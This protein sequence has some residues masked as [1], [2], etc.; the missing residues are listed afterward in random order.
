MTSMTPSREAGGRSSVRPAPPL[1]LVCAAGAWVAV[2]VLWLAMGAMPGTMGLSPVLFLGVWTLMMAAMMLP[3]VAPFGSFYT[4]TFT[5]HRERRLVAFVSGYLLAWAGAGVPA[6][7]LAWSVDRF[8]TGRATAATVLAVLIFLLCGVYQLT[9][10]KD[11][12]LAHCRSP[13]GFTLKYSTY[14]GRGRDLRAGALHGGFCLGCCWALMLV[15]IA[16]GLMNVLAMVGIAAVVTIEKNWR[17]G[18]P[19]ARTAGVVSIVLAAAVAVHPALAPG[20]YQAPRSTMTNG[21]M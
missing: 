2:G 20:L 8:I 7:A 5:V 9:P 1:P 6:F 13:L 12:C 16:F 10:L 11:R 19:I 17:W 14:R 18:V 4:R 15:L 3:G 21:T